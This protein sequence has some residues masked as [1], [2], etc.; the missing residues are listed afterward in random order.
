MDG[1]RIVIG[2]RAWVKQVTEHW[3]PSAGR[4]G[5]SEY[6][7]TFYEPADPYQWVCSG[8]IAAD[9]ADLSP[10]GLSRIFGRAESRAWRDPTGTYWKICTCPAP[11][12]PGNGGDGGPDILSFRRRD[13]SG[14]DVVTRHVRGLRPL[15]YLSDEELQET[16]GGA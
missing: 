10:E 5:P 15:G 2:E 6:S 9:G 7:V 11:K 13:E 8:R 3:A 12:P 1:D 14:T 4:N 16:L